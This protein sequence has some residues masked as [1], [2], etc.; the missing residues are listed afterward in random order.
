MASQ[1]MT[2]PNYQHGIIGFFTFFILALVGWRYGLS[3]NSWYHISYVLFGLNASEATST[4]ATKSAYYAHLPWQ[5]WA[6]IASVAVTSGVAG[7]FGW[8]VSAKPKLMERHVAG[9]E[10]WEGKHGRR[11][12]QA[13]ERKRFSKAQKKWWNRKVRGISLGGFEFSRDRERGMINIFGLPGGG[14]TVLLNWLILQLITF[15]KDKIILHDHKGDF[16]AWLPSS[17]KKSFIVFGPWDKRSAWWDI[18]EDVRTPALADSFAS[19]I[20]P[21]TEK[22]DIWNPAARELFAGVIKYLQKNYGPYKKGAPKWSWD[23]L[24]EILASGIDEVIRVA[25][26]A[27][28]NLKLMIPEKKAP[29]P[30]G[31]EQEQNRT[32][33]SV[34]FTISVGIGWIPV[35]AACYDLRN[36]DGSLKKGGLSITKWI[37]G[38][39]PKHP[40]LILKN[41]GRFEAR[42]QQI[43]GAFLACASS[44]ICSPAMPQLD[45]DEDNG[46]WIVLDEYPQLGPSLGAQIQPIEAL[47][48]SKGVRVVKASQD[49]SQLVE[50]YGKDKGQVQQNICQTRIYAKLS[51]DTASSAAAILK[52]RTVE[53]MS[54]SISGGD[55]KKTKSYSWSLCEVPVL[56]PDTLIGLDQVTKAGMLESIFNTI[57]L[58]R[59]AKKFATEKGVE[60]FVNFDNKATTS[61]SQFVD[62]AITKEVRPQVVENSK[63]DYGIFDLADKLEAK[64]AAAE[65]SAP[66]PPL[67]LA[68]LGQ[69]VED[70]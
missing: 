23:N 48:R 58:K 1:I 62:R 4:F 40:I 15:R 59:L 51:A 34:L 55:G 56:S 20:F 65:S 32:T 12:M 29:G 47:G 7:W 3:D 39:Y 2:K 69:V 13:A 70:D 67:D 9:I 68:N 21:S 46:I 41:D 24:A 63:W 25:Q 52:N 22:G 54:Y 30:D 37:A 64:K 31:K 43:F 17:K 45:P 27:D 33:Q 19:A 28:P 57:G 6:M 66:K 50:Q 5:A 18:A 44:Y 42:A 38:K 49:A 26:S 60:V 11:M 36:E 10:V 53:R 14:K 16:T 61:V 8:Y 35:Y